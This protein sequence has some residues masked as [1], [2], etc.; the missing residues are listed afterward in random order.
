MTAIAS[1]EQLA[2][3]YDLLVRGGPPPPPPPPPP[4]SYRCHLGARRTAPSRRI[5]SP[6]RYVL[7]RM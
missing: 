6:L 2:E 3:S 1:I 5:V 4:R 7:P